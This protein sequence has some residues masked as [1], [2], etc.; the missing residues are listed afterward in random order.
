M[1]KQM[2]RRNFIVVLGAAIMMPGVASAQQAR[3]MARVGVLWHAANA[4][5]EDPTSRRCNK[6]SKISWL[7]RRGA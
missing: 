2:K 3:R 4:E 1:D 5:E 6:G 7:R